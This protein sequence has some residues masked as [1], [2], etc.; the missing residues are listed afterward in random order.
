MHITGKLNEFQHL[1]DFPAEIT[2]FLQNM[3][4]ATAIHREIVTA[5]KVLRTDFG[6]MID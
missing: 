6:G 5:L 3:A 4:K 2:D 1:Q